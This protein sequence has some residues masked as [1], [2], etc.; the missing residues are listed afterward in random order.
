MTT[1]LCARRQS[2]VRHRNRSSTGSLSVCGCMWCLTPDVDNDKVPG[3]RQRPTLCI[4]Y[5]MG[6]G[7]RDLALERALICVCIPPETYRRAV[8]GLHP[9]AL[10]SPIIGDWPRRATIETKCSRKCAGAPTVCRRPEGA[11]GPLPLLKRAKET[12]H[13]WGRSVLS[14]AVP[15]P[16]HLKSCR[17]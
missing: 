17:M 10:N 7:F 3:S 9:E 14:A 13:P 1:T 6:W 2:K 8:A 5:F 11:G 16:A 15:G 12:G 4:C